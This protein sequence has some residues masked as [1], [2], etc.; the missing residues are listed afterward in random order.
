MDLSQ[1]IGH[2][3]K[4]SLK[5]LLSQTKIKFHRLELLHGYGGFF[6]LYPQ[7]K[8]RQPSRE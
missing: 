2:R 6:A 5:F 3:G 8:I 4:K 1:A 7:T